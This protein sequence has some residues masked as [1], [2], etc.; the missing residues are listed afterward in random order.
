VLFPLKNAL[1]NVAAVTLTT[2]IERRYKGAN[3]RQ[4]LL[5]STL[6]CIAKNVVH[7]GQVSAKQTERHQQK[8]LYE[9]A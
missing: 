7:I 1:F 8:W 4:K 2:A 9:Q 3:D 5:V 6:L